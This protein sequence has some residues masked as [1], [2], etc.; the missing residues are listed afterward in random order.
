MGDIFAAVDLTAVAAFVVAS[1][2]LI[3]G[4]RMAFKG[5]DLAKQ[6]VSKA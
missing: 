3:I 6:A 4:V 2:I 1:G 5:T